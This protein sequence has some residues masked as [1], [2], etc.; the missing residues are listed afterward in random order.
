MSPKRGDRAAPPPREDEFDVRFA[1]SDAAKG[2]DELCRQAPGNVRT[3][4]EAIR[5][6]PRPHPST[7]GST[8]S[9][10]P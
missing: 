9:S 8:G 2:W 7:S 5:R 4:F 1:N 3:A 10:T 6:A